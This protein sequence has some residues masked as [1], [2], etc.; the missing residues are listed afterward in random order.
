MPDVVLSIMAH[1]DDAEILCGGVL[2]RL[3]RKHG[4]QAHIATMTP[5]DCGSAELPPE[6]ISCVRRQEGAAAAAQLGGVYHCLEERDLLVSYE[7][8][9]LAKVTRLLREVRPRIVIT[10]SPADY[11]LDHEM[12][13]ALAR[14][15]VF[16]APIPNFLRAE[17]IG[18]PLEHMP[19]LYY[20]DPIEGKDA[21]GREVTPAFCIDISSVI[22]EKAALLACHASQ[23]DWLLKHHG[24]D[25][26][27]EAMRHWSAQR[28]R[29]VGVPFAEG[30]RQHLGHSYP[31][32]N[33][34]VQLLGQ[35]SPS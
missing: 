3:V 18:P 28:G 2:V 34:L 24:I 27:L 33:L 29:Q 15:A 35:C 17:G 6:E 23:R 22:A 5:G 12:T 19:H 13:S 30:Y 9:T 10:H 31:Q 4:W 21:L 26:Y 1:P 14:A 8:R 7:P 20:A 11:M 16:A 25:H 32:D